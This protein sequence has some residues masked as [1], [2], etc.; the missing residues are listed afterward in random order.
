MYV[1]VSLIVS[2]EDC[3]TLVVGIIVHDVACPYFL[4]IVHMVMKTGT[5]EACV[6]SVL[7]AVLKEIVLVRWPSLEMMNGRPYCD[8]E[9]HCLNC[10]C[11]VEHDWFYPSCV[12]ALSGGVVGRNHTVAVV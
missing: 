1:A 12:D 6:P 3:A 10:R 7:L 11:L 9:N 4:V 5:V 8:D 2:V